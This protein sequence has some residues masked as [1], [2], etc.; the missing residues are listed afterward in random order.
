MVIQA[1]EAMLKPE[2]IT[3]HAVIV[4]CAKSGGTWTAVEWLSKAQ[5]ARL[6]PEVMAYHAVV[7]TCAKSGD[8][9]KVTEWLSKRRRPRWS[10][11][12]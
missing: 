5:E 9:E 12:S 11:R 6:E 1:Q 7:D 4:A 8:M 3:Y 2:I 10:L